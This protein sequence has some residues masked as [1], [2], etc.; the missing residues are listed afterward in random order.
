MDRRRRR[1]LASPSPGARVAV[2]RLGGLGCEHTQETGLRLWGQLAGKF[3]AS[4]HGEPSDAPTLED[5][6]QVMRVI[7]AV[8]RSDASGGWESV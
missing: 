7:D 5:G 1:Q 4:I 2:R 8:R 6:W 3:V